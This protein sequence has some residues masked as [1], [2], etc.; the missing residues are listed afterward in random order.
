MSSYASVENKPATQPVIISSSTPTVPTPPSPVP[1]ATLGQTSE[2]DKVILKVDPIQYYIKASFMITY[3]LLLTTATITFIEAMRTENP[4]VRHILNLETC[5]SIVAGYFYSLFLTQ[6]ET[7]GKGNAKEEW[8]DIIKTRYVDWS[9]TT[10]L[11]I[12]VL[13]AFLVNESGKKIKLPLLLLILL[14]NWI[15]LAFGYF[16]ETE[17]ISRTIAFVGGFVAFFGFIYLI[18]KNFVDMS[19]GYV[20]NSLFFFYLVA[21]TFYGLVYL[22]PVNHQNIALNFLDCV[23][24]CFVGIGIWFYYTKLF[25]L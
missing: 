25:V 5:I 21:W 7:F 10:P 19:L 15:M 18:F 8:G 22:L 14:L 1:T 12:I 2:K 4:I 11:M 17:V 13:C 9:L 16:G 20:K 6:I 24:K 3:I 23:S